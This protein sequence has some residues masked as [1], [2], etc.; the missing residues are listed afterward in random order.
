MNTPDI[1]GVY[2]GLFKRTVAAWAK[3]HAELDAVCCDELELVGGDS[4]ERVFAARKTDKAVAEI[5]SQ[6]FHKLCGIA[7]REFGLG[8]RPLDLPL[9]ELREENLD[10]NQ[11]ESFDPAALWGTLW[12]RYG[13]RNGETTAFAQ[14]A[15]LIEREFAIK[16]GTELK[17]VT[18]RVVLSTDV[19]TSVQK[20]SGRVEL[21]YHAALDLAKLVSALGVFAAWMHD[22]DLQAQL[23]KYQRS[24]CDMHT[25]LVTR[26]R[27]SLTDALQVVT[28]R[29]RFEFR[30]SAPVAAQLQVFLA[31][32]G[33]IG[34]NIERSGGHHHVARD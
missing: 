12:A 23:S 26:E 17:T 9:F 14:A 28:F 18:G 3:L 21:S 13:G 6:I 33:T 8:G 29:A 24:H 22:I 27:I 19:Q 25:N 30:F 2:A 10:K 4:W 32:Y 16:P 20:F 11:S 34:A 31:E 1:G 5:A 15:R 7:S